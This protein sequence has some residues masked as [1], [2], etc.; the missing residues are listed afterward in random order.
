MKTFGGISEGLANYATA[1]ILLQSIPYDGTSTWIK[2]ADKGFDAFLEASENMELYDIE[3]ESEVYKNGIHVLKEILEKSS[4]EKVFKEVYTKTK[5]LLKSNK[6]LTFFGGEHSISIGIIKAFY[7]KYNNLTVLQLDAHADL[8]SSYMGSEYNHACALYNANKNTNLIQ[9]GIRSM[10]ISEKENMNLNNVFFAKDMT[11]DKGWMEQS[12]AKMT[13]DIYITLD[14]DVFDPSI[15]PSTGTP[16]PGGIIWTDMVKFLNKVFEE[17]NVV[18]FDI[19][20][21][22]PIENLV[23]P[24][25]L[26]AKLYYKMLSYKFKNQ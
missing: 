17:K 9:L 11:K 18:G 26:V 3:T 22:A 15:M 13:N 16:E 21:L 20:E 19:V 25:F 2:G 1:E 5:E 8:R 12:I 23:A 4:P 6:F 7:E 14:L 10:D 24:N